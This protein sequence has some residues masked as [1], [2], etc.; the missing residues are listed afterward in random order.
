MI[1]VCVFNWLY[2]CEEVLSSWWVVGFGGPE[3]HFS[4]GHRAAK[5]PDKT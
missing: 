2:D 4:L 1:A 5:N 3:G